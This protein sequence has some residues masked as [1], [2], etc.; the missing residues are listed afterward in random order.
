[1]PPGALR[2]EACERTGG[3]AINTSLLVIS[4]FA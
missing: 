3:G 4:S 1:M 2:Q